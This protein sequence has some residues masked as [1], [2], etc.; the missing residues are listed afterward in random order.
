MVG[1]YAVIGLVLLGGL[2][3]VAPA[4]GQDST[5]RIDSQHSAAHLFLDSSRNSEAGVS[6]GVA[7]ASGVMVGSAG[8]SV[9]SDFDFTIY[10]PDKT[11]SPE[12]SAQERGGE[13]PVDNANYNVI[14]F[15][16]KRVVQLSGGSFRVTGDLTLTYVE[17]LA[18][19]AQGGAYSGAVYGPAVTESVTQPAV[20]EFGQ[21]SGPRGT[22]NNIAEWS[23]S[24]AMNGEDFPELLNAVS[25][26][27]CPT[28]GVNEK[29]DM[30]SNEGKGFSG[31]VC[32]GTTI[33]VASGADVHREMPSVGGD[34][35]GEMCGETV[36]VATT[37]VAAQR[38]EPRHHGDGEQTRLAAN[39]VR[40]QLD[41]QLTR[42]D[43][44]ASVG[45]RP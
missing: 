23:A 32:T 2:I 37:H 40:M 34:F 16:S 27:R 29:C 41:L 20:F 45:S 24:S 38:S 12:S 22:Q 6:V 7:R 14:R 44:R 17:Q 30:P 18:T 43:S 10:P 3:A 42:V 4:L 25:N 35:A 1:K 26:T 28:F 21:V 19:H 33:E 5:W 9:P 31:P 13:N 8:N 11:A 36:P 39:E 15:K